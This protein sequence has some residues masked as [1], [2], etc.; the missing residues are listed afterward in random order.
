MDIDLDLYR[1]EIRTSSDPIVRLSAIDVSP[2]SPLRT[3]VFIHGFG[4]TAPYL[5]ALGNASFQADSVFTDLEPG[6]YELFLQ[7]ARG[8][9]GAAMG[10]VTAAVGFEITLIP[11]A[12]VVTQGDTV[13]ISASGPSL[14]KVEWTP[15][16]SLDCP[17][18]LSVNAY[19]VTTTT[20]TV[21]G[22]N[23]AGCMDSA[24]VVITVLPKEEE[25]GGKLFVPNA[26][27]P[28]GNGIN[29]RFEVFVED[30]SAEIQSFQVFNRWGDLVFDGG[31]VLPGQGMGYWD[32]SW[33][34]RPAEPGVYVWQLAIVFA[35]GRSEM[36]K[37]S[38]VL[39]R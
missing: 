19:P 10:A 18:C 37:G 27:S 1:H 29:D 31:S 25:A 23:N 32:G 9:E 38:V 2:E 35:N 5:Y 13:A 39:I 21:T 11:S 7:D 34:G 6:Q 26:F 8:C 20:Y 22:S 24:S 28:D 4:G 16:F 14:D 33:K 30:P 15:A 36:H 17:T 12:T 3:I